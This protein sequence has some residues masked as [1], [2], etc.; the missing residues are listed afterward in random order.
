M[1]DVKK[2]MVP[3]LEGCQA[4]FSEHIEK[5]WEDRSLSRMMSN[6]GP[7]PPQKKVLDQLVEGAKLCHRYP[8]SLKH[9][10]KKIG[11]LNSGLD[12]DWVLLGNGSTEGLD[13]TMRAFLRPGEAIIQSNPCYGIYSKRAALIGADTITIDALDG[14]E[15]DLDSIEASISEKVKVVILANPNNPTGNLTPDTVYERLVKHNIIVICDEAYIEYSGLENSKVPIIKK[16]PNMI[17]SR[18]LSKAYGLA[19]MRFGYL[20]GHP[21][22]IAIISRMVMSWNVSTISAFGA[23]A[24]LLDQDGLREKARMTNEGRDYIESELSKIDGLTVYHTY[25]NYILIDATPTGA[26]SAEIVNAVMEKDGIILRQMTPFKEKTG[27]FRI[28]IS[29]REENERCVE[30]VKAFFSSRS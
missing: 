23:Y 12:P 6:E 30:A 14:W 8:D 27:L 19:G 2:L 25:G 13:M 17:I 1:A 5:A 10:K 24:A 3:W 28:T 18:T 20:L 26:T 22:T 9:I 4:Y 11:E 15:Y 7:M 29:S 21:E 16:N